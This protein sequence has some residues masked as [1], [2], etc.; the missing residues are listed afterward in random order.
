MSQPTTVIVPASLRATEK[1]WFL[2]RRH[3]RAGARTALCLN[4]N[5]GVL[6]LRSTASALGCLSASLKNSE[7]CGHRP[8]WFR[9]LRR[10]LSSCPGDFTASNPLV[11]F[12]DAINRKPADSDGLWRTV[13]LVR[14]RFD[15]QQE[16][17]ASSSASWLFPL[18][19]HRFVIL[20]AAKGISSRWIR[21]RSFAALRMTIR[22]SRKVGLRQ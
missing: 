11:R 21:M 9:T 5:D 4:S 16:G 8:R 2:H 6:K 7:S 15:R 20:S 10:R 1:T 14:M 3:P 13:C 17:F 22:C 19:A 18:I 12:L